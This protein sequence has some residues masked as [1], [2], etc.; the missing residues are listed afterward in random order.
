[1]TSFTYSAGLFTADLEDTV[2]IIIE[3]NEKVSHKLLKCMINGIDLMSLSH[4]EEDRE[5]RAMI[6][7]YEKLAHLADIVTLRNNC[8]DDDIFKKCYLEY[9]IHFEKMKRIYYESRR[10]DAEL[11]Y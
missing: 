2:V 9:S 7:E 4:E 5:L 1:M 10:I 8:I 11:G 6:Q 3:D